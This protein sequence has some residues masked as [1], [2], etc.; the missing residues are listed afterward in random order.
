MSWTGLDWTA[1]GRRRAATNLSED[2]APRI[3]SG[4]VKQERLWTNPAMGLVV[5]AA[6]LGGEQLV[7]E[8]G[9]GRI[10]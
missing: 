2:A 1:R 9:V 4:A 3:R 6:A 7:G 8:W 10:L 5:V